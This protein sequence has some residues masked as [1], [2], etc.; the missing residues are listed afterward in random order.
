MRRVFFRASCQSGLCLAW[1][2]SNL[3]K[4]KEVNYLD[5]MDKA[6]MDRFDPLFTN[7]AGSAM[8]P[9]KFSNGVKDAIRTTMP[10]IG[11]ELFKNLKNHSCRSAIP[12]ICQELEC[13]ID[14]D[15]LKSLG[16]WESDAYLQYLKSYQGALKT[17]RFVE[18]EIIKKISDAKKQRT[19]FFNQD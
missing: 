13:F 6:G 10:G 19:L 12:T 18:E 7:L 2:P 17:R 4:V 5:R 1:I 14:K 9:G 16:R 15:I 3:N 8:T 11:H